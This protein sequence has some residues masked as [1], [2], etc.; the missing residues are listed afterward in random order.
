MSINIRRD[1][2]DP[3]YRYKMPPLVAKVEG[4]GNGIKTAVVNTSDVARALNRPPAYVIKFFGFELGA[5]TS[6]NQDLERYIVNGAHD[7]PK[8]QDCLDVFISKFV[9]C[10]SCQNPETDFIIQKDGSVYK[11]C[12]ACGAKTIVDPRHKLTSF[13]IKNPPETSKSK[14]KGMANAGASTGASET[15]GTG[16]GGQGA[17]DQGENQPGDEGDDELT[18][19][20][21]AEAAT[22]P[23]MQATKEED[24]EWTADVSEEA[25]KAR[26]KQL[27]RK[28]AVLSMQEQGTSVEALDEFGEWIER[29]HPCDVEIFKRAAELNIADRPETLQVLGQALFTTNL[30]NEIEPH[31]GLLNKLVVTEQHEKALLGGLERFIGIIHPELVKSV[32]NVLFKL[33]DLDIISEDVVSRWC[34]KVS[35]RYV[36]KETSRKVRLAAK[37]FLEWL[38]QATDDSDEE[39]DDD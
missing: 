30:V 16:S 21:N 18:R 39:S 37:P 5:Q 14:K 13:I 8:L 20:I 4:R 34:T 38:E 6:L 15:G 23:E 35:K 25:V 28:I 3:F 24:E 26:Q 19:R 27:Q 12:K 33:Y 2:K 31:S 17:E 32:P 1:N 29:E 11:D 36:D 10:G 9:L 7:A 22:L